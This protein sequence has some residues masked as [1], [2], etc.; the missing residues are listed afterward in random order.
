MTDFTI[1][2]TGVSSFNDIH[3]AAVHLYSSS[4][5]IAV[6]NDNYNLGANP[7]PSYMYE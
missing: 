6:G 4:N 3:V 7:S 5:I 1:T 2:I